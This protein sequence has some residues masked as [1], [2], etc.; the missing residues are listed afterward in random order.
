MQFQRRRA[1]SELM[2]SSLIASRDLQEGVPVEGT[3][4]RHLNANSQEQR[5]LLSKAP[6]AMSARLLA[7]RVRRNPMDGEAYKA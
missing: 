5:V 2:Q 6:V 1:V 4:G 7:D 3:A